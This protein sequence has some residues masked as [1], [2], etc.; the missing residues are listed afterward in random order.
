[1]THTD[2]FAL[3]SAA[4]AAAPTMAEAEARAAHIVAAWTETRLVN[5]D[6]RGLSIEEAFEA[7]TLD[8]D[9]SESIG[10]LFDAEAHTYSVA[11]QA[12]QDAADRDLYPFEA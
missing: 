4:V 6:T 11:E 7:A 3:L 1:M 9:W 2:T 10:Y 8:A 12:E 5:R